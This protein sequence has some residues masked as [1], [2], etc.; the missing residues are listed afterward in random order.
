MD[1]GVAVA[2]LELRGVCVEVLGESGVCSVQ[3]IQAS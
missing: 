2:L 1:V 3:M